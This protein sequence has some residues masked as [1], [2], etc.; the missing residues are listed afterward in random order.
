MKR[1]ISLLLVIA[2]LVSMVHLPV[3]AAGTQVRAFMN[4]D[5]AYF[6]SRTEEISFIAEDGDKD[7]RN[8]AL[9]SGDLGSIYGL[10][11]RY[12]H[13]EGWV[14]DDDEFGDFGYSING[15]DIVWGACYSAEA[16]LNSAAGYAYCFRYNLTLDVQEGD[17]TIKFFKMLSTGE[18]RESKTLT[19]SNEASAPEIDPVIDQ[20]GTHAESNL[21]IGVD[22]MT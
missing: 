9:G 10:G 16:G 21:Q 12:F 20:I 18:T 6:T 7:V 22:V 1:R 17:V 2:L 14:A 4:V 11:Y 8:E 13:I 3:T 19:Y 15:G 5:G